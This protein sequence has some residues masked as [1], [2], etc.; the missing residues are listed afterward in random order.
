MDIHIYLLCYNESALLPHAIRH[1]KKNLPSCKIYIYDNESTDNSVEIAKN[2]GCFIIPWSS[3]NCINDFKY[4]QIKNNCWKYLKRGWVIMADMDEFLCVTEEDLARE[5]KLGTSVLAIRGYDII[6]ETE[7]L[8]LSDID[9]QKIQ[10]YVENPWESKNLCFLR[11]KIEEMEYGYGAHGC[12][13]KGDVKY[14]STI[15]I[16][17]HMKMLGLNYLTHNYTKLYER[18][19]FMRQYGGALHYTSDIEAIKKKYLDALNNSKNL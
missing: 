9:L 1:Y 11:E 3:D 6:G 8:D 4:K 17:K 5:M 15:Y 12:K 18:A 10:K 16:N 7:T 19:A 13:P 14:S 2:L